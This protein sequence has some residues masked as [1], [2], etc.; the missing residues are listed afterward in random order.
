MRK[1]IAAAVL[2]SGLAMLAGCGDKE[3][4]TLPTADENL[5]LNNAAEMLDASPDSA[6][7]NEDAPLGNGEVDVIEAEESAN[8]GSANTA[9]NSQ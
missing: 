3:D 4:S 8:Q 2:A 5:Q 1:L 6:T 7:A 9:G